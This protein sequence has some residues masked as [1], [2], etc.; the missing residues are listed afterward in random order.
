MSR[1]DEAADRLRQAAI[2]KGD[3]A[4]SAP[5]DHELHRIMGDACRVLDEEGAPGSEALRRLLTDESPHVRKWVAA[6]LLSRGEV[7]ARPV[8]EELAVLSGQ[9]A[10]DARFTLQ[11]H[12]AGRL[13]S[14]FR[15]GDTP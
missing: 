5:R 2:D 11:E 6:E 15:T 14:P 10:F 1:I 8:L 7:S 9:L 13:R 3:I 4:S 12:L